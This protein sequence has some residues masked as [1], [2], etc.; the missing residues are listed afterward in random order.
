M[1][2]LHEACNAD[3][4]FVSG[5]TWQNVGATLRIAIDTTGLGGVKTGT[6]VYLT[7]I[8]QSWNACPDIHH[9]FIIFS[10]PKTSGY[11]QTLG[12]DQ[13]FRFIP[14][15][16]S[17]PLRI[18]WQQAVL[19]R[20]LARLDIDVHWGCGFTL[21]IL[22]SRPMVVTIYDLTFQLYPE[23]HERL[24]RYYFPKMI[25]AA[26]KKARRVV[27]IS[28]TTR[29]DIFRL[30]PASRGKT[31]VTLLAPRVLPAAASPPAATGSDYMICLGTLEPRKNLPRLLEAWLSINDDDRKGIKLVVVGVRG[32]MVDEV[33]SKYGNAKN[34]II[35]TGFVDDATLRGLFRGALALVYPS[36]YE[37][38]GLP[39]VEAMAEGVPVLTSNI[40]ATREIAEGA[41]LLVDPYSIS[42]I[43]EGLCQIV[44]DRDLRSRLSALG[45]NRAAQFS[46]QTTANQTLAILE[47]AA[48]QRQA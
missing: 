8:L 38:F 24:K 6:G 18:L 37:G 27:A 4:F 41:A 26:V 31:D 15:P 33:L 1:L 20:H 30:L 32:W 25:A 19:P 36:I 40:G 47:E 16:D 28:E 39:V 23:V 11:L 3:L 42:S 5:N 17:R 46:W 10:S 14:A 34:S 48:T 45:R 7:E 2:Q 43:R 13:R 22:S 29:Q 12:L 35:F 9:E 44:R 21:P